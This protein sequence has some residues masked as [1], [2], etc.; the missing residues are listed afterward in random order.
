MRPLREEKP[1]LLSNV[2][3]RMPFERKH[4]KTLYDSGPKVTKIEQK[5]DVLLDFCPLESYYG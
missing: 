1:W 5:C 2:N 3:F 4:L